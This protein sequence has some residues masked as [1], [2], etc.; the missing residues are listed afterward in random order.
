[1]CFCRAYYGPVAACWQIL[2]P[3]TII[4]QQE[5]NRFSNTTT[6]LLIVSDRL[7]FRLVS[8]VRHEIVPLRPQRTTS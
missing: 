8:L 3:G 2:N 5:H 7:E 4:Q 1:M 6:T